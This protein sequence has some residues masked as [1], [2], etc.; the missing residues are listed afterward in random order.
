[1]LRCKNCGDELKVDD[2]A[3]TVH[4]TNGDTSYYCSRG[5]LE[6]DLMPV[7]IGTITTPPPGTG[8]S[9]TNVGSSSAAILNFVIP[10]SEKAKSAIR[11]IVK[12]E[13][14]NE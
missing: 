7:Y 8:T 5:C 10:K 1:M 4:G 14:P 12:E 6:E 2:I 13:V 11:P 3:H 9:V